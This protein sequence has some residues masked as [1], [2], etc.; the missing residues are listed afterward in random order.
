M[1]EDLRKILEE[2]DVELEVSFFLKGDTIY[3]FVADENGTGATYPISTSE[4]IGMC[5]T[6]FFSPCEEV[7]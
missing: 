6:S 2:K 4:T 1:L 7:D 3:M 5:L